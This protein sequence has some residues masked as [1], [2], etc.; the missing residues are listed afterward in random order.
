MVDKT[1]SIPLYFQ[2]KDQ[3]FQEIEDGIYKTGER[4][5]PERELIERFN[6]A[7]MT[8]R[9]AIKILIDQG[10]LE[11]RRG[12]GV[13]VADR[14]HF[15]IEQNSQRNTNIGILLPYIK[16]GIL[17]D[18]LRGIEDQAIAH[19]YNTNIC[20][21]N[22]SWDKAQRYV[23]QL[24]ANQVQG[25][26][27]LPIQEWDNRK[28]KDDLN[29]QIIT[30]LNK[31][32]IPIVLVD[33]DCKSCVADLVASDNFGGGYKATK[34]LIEM[35]HTKIAVIHEYDDTSVMDR[36]SGYK[37]A[38]KEYN[39]PVQTHYIHKIQKDNPDSNF[40]E[41]LQ[42]IVNDL[43]V[44]AIFAIHDLLAVYIGSEA[45]SLGIKIPE[46]LS[47]VG[48]DN[49]PFTEHLPTP[50]T[51]VDQPVYKIGIESFNLLLNRMKKNTLKVEKIFLSNQLIV[52]KSV[53]KIN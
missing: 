29:R 33:R 52:R 18:L 12:S 17:V 2:I 49:L 25:A 24:I 41:T 42:Y 28:E 23:D 8:L 20:N 11:S 43:N 13:Y 5:P 34:H 6:V 31:H 50:L 53:K 39:L 32:K 48:Y 38:L 21:L 36:I 7:R 51:T 19:G 45:N 44:T 46:H 10:F 16:Q 37:A 35:G 1:S 40:T 15:S 4:L 27:Y 30:E 9:Q 26:I 22:S 47:L 3:L 14:H